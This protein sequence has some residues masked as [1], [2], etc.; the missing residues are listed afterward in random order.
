MI[1][2]LDPTKAGFF[3]GP[4]VIIKVRLFSQEGVEAGCMSVFWFAF[5]PMGLFPAAV[6]NT[7]TG[8]TG[9]A[10]LNSTEEERLMAQGDFT[11]QDQCCFPLFSKSSLGNV[12]VTLVLPLF[13]YREIL[14][15]SILS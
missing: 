14:V 9:N 2:D 11:E 7:W 6:L 1:Y 15:D 4:V 8:L 12:A 5:V 3:F 10:A 13:L